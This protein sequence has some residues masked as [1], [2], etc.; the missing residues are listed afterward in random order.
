QGTD[1]QGCLAT[2]V[3]T[4]NVNGSQPTLSVVSSTPST[5]LGKTA[6]L[7]ASG[8]LTYTWT[9]GVTNGVSFYPSTT[10]TYTVSGQNGC[11]I[12]TA[13]STISVN[14]LPITVVSTNSVVCTNKTA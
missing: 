1:T 9:N 5:C 10:T 13:V 2:S 4:V 8:A 11:G 6:T 7:T 14:P 3:L 12:T